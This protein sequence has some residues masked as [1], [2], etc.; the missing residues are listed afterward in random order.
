VAG[1]TFVG[2]DEELRG[3]QEF[4]KRPEGEMLLITGPDGSG[5]SHLLRRLRREAEGEERHFVLF[6]ELW[7]LPEADLRQYSVL[8]ALL[9]LHRSGRLQGGE[10]S[11]TRLFV[12]SEEF[13]DSL[14]RAEDAPP[15]E[16]LLRALSVTAETLGGGSRLVALLDLG[17]S[18]EPEVFPLA[19]F[20]SERLDRIKLVVAKPTAPPELVDVPGVTVLPPLS[21]LT[22]GEA[23]EL[24]EFHLPEAE[25][26]A[27]LAAA[28]RKACRGHPLS[29]DVAAKLA[30]GADD[31]N[32]EMGTLPSEV[33]ALCR[34]LARTLEPAQQRLAASIARVPSGVGINLLRSVTDLP[35]RQLSRLIRTDGMRNVLRSQRT[36]GGLH[37]RLFHEAFTEAILEQVHDAR[38][39]VQDF[40]RRAAAFFLARVEED[41]T[42]VDALSAHAYHLEES[43]DK[44]QFIADFAKTY[45]A[46]H[47]FHLLRRLAD[48][49]RRLIEYCDE[50]DVTSINLGAC[51]ANLG[52]VLQQ[53]DQHDEAMRRYQEALELY[54]EQ[55]DSVGAAE[56]HANL[57]SAHQAM[58]R[59]AEAVDSLEQA[60]KLDQEAGNKGGLAADYNNLGIL[61]QQLGQPERA[62]KYHQQALALHEE[63]DNDVGRA[64]QYANL[65]AIHRQLGNLEEAR[66]SYQQAWRLDTKVN[67]TLAQVADLCHLGEVFDDLGEVQK[68][69]SCYEQAIELDRLTA[70][71]EAEGKHLRTLAAARQKA[72]QHDEAIE[73]LHRALQVHRAAGAEEGEAAD[74]MALGDVCA[75]TGDLP[76]ARDMF[77]QAQQLCARIGDAEGEQAA[78][79]ALEDVLHRIE[80]GPTEEA[81]GESPEAAAEAERAPAEQT[82]PEATEGEAAQQDSEDEERL[83]SELQEALRRVAELERQLEGYKDVVEKIRASNEKEPPTE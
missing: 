21:P 53:L 31:P 76:L 11:G 34:D 62:L 67:S 69:I 54:Q 41:P 28:A 10:A 77:E 33:S 7:P 22:E 32:H 47:K 58:G 29:L 64:N 75:E 9:K 59:F 4:L 79:Q 82:E 60:A 24:F 5:K 56:Q 6:N 72:G 70:D 20:A 42:D 26:A 49:Y 81:E 23:A 19:F 36:L 74:L 40:H 27:E 71:H 63:L 65:G 1:F 48:E 15:C 39:A 17:R 43:G 83:T 35:D 16:R 50:L 44:R 12:K 8:I 25:D 30:A 57:A 38:D 45:K 61:C 14:L 13:L 78:E 51:L 2:R 66:D 3:F 68:A 52:R 18:D 73:T 80:N 46:K 37:A 55:N